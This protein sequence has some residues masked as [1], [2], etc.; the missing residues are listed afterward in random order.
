MNCA[1]CER[2]FDAYLDGQLTGSLR[3][4]LDAHRL[5]CRRCQQALA[6]M[7]AFEHVVMS[8]RRAPALSDD[9]TRRVMG[10]IH[11]QRPLVKRLFGT[12]TALALGALAQAAAVVLLAVLLPNGGPKPNPS[13]TLL[14]QGNSAA[15]GK[16]YGE[17]D[18]RDYIWTRIHAINAA[19]ANFS[20][21]F[22][23]LSRYAAN[24][25]VSGD[26]VKFVNAD[27]V[28]GLLWA[29]IPQ[30][31]ESEPAPLAADQYSL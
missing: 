24:W 29:L 18:L 5:R 30:P 16:T 7:E 4:E 31:E 20:A 27:P 19:K 14:A 11:Q 13:N 25:N 8:D 28:S 2:L 26:V 21:D 17:D 15:P 3:L 10:K 23:Q 12:R 6:M 9:F 22:N 1:E